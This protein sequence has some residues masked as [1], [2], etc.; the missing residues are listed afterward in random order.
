MGFQDAH[1]Q[2]HPSEQLSLFDAHHSTR[3]RARGRS[4]RRAL[5]IPLTLLALGLATAGILT[6]SYAAWTAQTSNP[7]NAVTAGTLAITNSKSGSSVFAATN[8]K[9]GDTGSGTVVVSN[10]GSV[11][12][13]VK[14]TQDNVTATG[15]EASLR[16]KVHDQTRNRCYWPVDQ[17]GACPA[18]Y[19]AW[20][21]TGT[22]NAKALPATSGAATWPAS[23]AH[24]FTISWQLVASSPN[25][26]QGKTGSFRLVWNGT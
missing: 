8:V 13:A 17:A 19:G 2:Y 18:G 25:S 26:D 23:E 12:L 5:Q 4:R 22:L 20:N 14:L 24:T 1:S 9:P 3:T 7:S 16:L 6:G 11:P 15:I 10:S 21:A